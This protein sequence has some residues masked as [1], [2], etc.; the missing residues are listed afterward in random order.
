LGA[1]FDAMSE[2]TTTNKH[3]DWFEYCN[4]VRARFT[5][6]ESIEEGIDE[7]GRVNSYYFWSLFDRLVPFDQVITMGNSRVNAA[8]LQI[9]V[10]TQQQRAI[11]NYLCG[12]MGYDLPAAVGV[13]VATG[14]NIICV[15][16]DGSIMMN[17]QEL[18]TISHNHLPVKVIL[19]SNDGY[20][21]IRQTNLNF[22]GGLLVGCSP[23]SGISFPDFHLTAEGFGFTYMLCSNNGEL[24][25]SLK[26][27]LSFEGRAFLEVRQQIPNPVVPK[28]MSRMNPD[29]SFQTPALQDMAPFISSKELNELMKVSR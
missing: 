9:G 10:E 15:T 23:E 21:A 3:E 18:Q 14:S 20:E 5:P 8:K 24:E 22:F 26:D 17:L 2:K 16:G 4:R 11:T 25:Q 1:F 27:F 12:S 29:G 7:S 19:F 28:L 6:F 13:S